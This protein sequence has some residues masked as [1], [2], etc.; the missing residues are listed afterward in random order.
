MAAVP[1]RH[2]SHMTKP[3]VCLTPI[4][5]GAELIPQKYQEQQG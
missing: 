5:P 3:R 2:V 1:P 4:N